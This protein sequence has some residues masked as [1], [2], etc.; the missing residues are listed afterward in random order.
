MNQPCNNSM[1]E[2]VSKIHD[3]T[4]TRLS[5][6]NIP[7]QL[8]QPY[9]GARPVMTKYSRLP[10][11]DP[12][13]AVTVPLMQLPD[14]N[15]NAIFNPGNTKSPWSGFASNV[16][17]ESSLRNQVFALQKCSQA[18]YVPSSNSDLYQYSF[19]PQ[20][21]QNGNAH[22]L[23]FSES[24]FDNF[25]PNPDNKIVGSGVFYNSTRTQ[26]KELGDVK[27]QC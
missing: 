2:T 16:N 7:S 23:L 21:Q 9:L 18:A 12:R 10:V 26:V 14:Y 4:N 25:N 15:S 27:P 22:S 19:T 11:V 5:D 17:T 20:Q 13:K 6:R 8:L 3:Q 24:H 1:D